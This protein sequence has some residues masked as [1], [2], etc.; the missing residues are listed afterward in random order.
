MRARSLLNTGLGLGGP[1]GAFEEGLSYP[2]GRPLSE[3]GVSAGW[4]GSSALGRAGDPARAAFA[5]THSAF[6]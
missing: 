4:A 1:G 2:L 5:A 6:Q 3:Q